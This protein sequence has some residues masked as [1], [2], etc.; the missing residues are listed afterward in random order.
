[1]AKCQLLITI[2]LLR[3]LGGVPVEALKRAK[4]RR[5]M[6]DISVE[7]LEISVEELEI[8]ELPER[9]TTIISDVFLWIP[10]QVRPRWM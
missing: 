9:N 10:W 2:A 4:E 6:D 8:S 1:L 5:R 3:R 7:E